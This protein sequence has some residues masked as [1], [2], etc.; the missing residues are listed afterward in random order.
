MTFTP[1]EILGPT[2]LS[3]HVYPVMKSTATARYGRGRL[4]S[5]E[6][7][8]ASRGR[9]RDR[10]RQELCLFGSGH[11]GDR[12]RRSRDPLARRIVISTYTISLQ[13]QLITKDLPLL[14][15]VIP[16]EFSAVLVK[17]RHNYLSLRRMSG[18]RPGRHDL[19]RRS[20]VHR[21]AA[22][23]TKWSARR[24]TVAGRPAHRPLPRSGTKRKA[25]TATAWAA[26]PD[27]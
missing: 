15:A 25:I 22:Q 6:S 23:F 26:M 9:G 3:R 11:P 27:L 5:L 13:E 17:G 10:G 8:A 7:P 12:R 19:S 16:L 21:D 2:G 4:A 20:R 1:A 18:Y 14:N 24:A